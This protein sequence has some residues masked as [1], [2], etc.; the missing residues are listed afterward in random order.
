MRNDL[1][2]RLK[3]EFP[4]FFRDLYGPPQETCMHR[5]C[6]CGDGWFEIVR[7]LCLRLQADIKARPEID[8]RLTQVKEKFGLLRVYCEGG[9]DR[10]M[11]IIREAQDASAE[12]CEECGRREGVVH[13]KRSTLCLVCRT[14]RHPS[15]SEA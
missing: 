6:E 10:V 3:G 2:V 11:A 8:L 13:D 7:A 15:I 14:T 5:G 1:K 4:A 9:D 12:A